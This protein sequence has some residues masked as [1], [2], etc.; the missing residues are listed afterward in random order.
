MPRPPLLPALALT[1]LVCAAPAAR[2]GEPGERALTGDLHQLGDAGTMPD[3]LELLLS[4]D[5][6]DAEARRA[7]ERSLDLLLEDYGGGEVREA[8][9]YLGALAGM[10]EALNW[11][12]ARGGPRGADGA[13]GHNALLTE[14]DATHVEHLQDGL[15]TGIGL[16]F[17]AST[18]EGVL[19]ISRVVEDSPA[20]RGGVR[21]GDRVVAIDGTSLQGQSLD[22]VLGMLRGDEGTPISLTLVRGTRPALRIDVVLTRATYAIPSVEVRLIDDHH[23]LVRISQFHGRTAHELR[24]EIEGL[25][26][27]GIEGI[28]LDLRGNQGGLLEAVHDVASLLLAD[29]TVVV[30]A[31]DARGRDV[32]LLAAGPPAFDGA[33]VCVVNRWTSSGAEALAATLQENDRAVLVG[34][35]TAGKDSAEALYELAPGLS[36]RMTAVRL[37]SPLG[38][39]WSGTGLTPDYLV[40]GGPV[41]SSSGEAPWPLTDVQIS[42][43]AELLQGSERP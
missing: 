4:E 28:V 25:T 31:E 3:N 20:D 12:T 13:T 36:L 16:E 2:A 19:Y 27:A 17:Q 35:A 6:T 23:A 30:L 32:Q 10:V 1:V 43:A 7:F 14:R 34:E 38:R 42:F 21:A 40:Q 33:L 24:E 8:D 41:Q 22:G 9:L 37:R 15:K 26:E 18:S 29:G 11:S 39:A 5:L